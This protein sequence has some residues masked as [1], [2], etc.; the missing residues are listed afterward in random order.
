MLNELA[1]S[2]D[3]VILRL[4]GSADTTDVPL[5]GYWALVGQLRDRASD[6]AADSTSLSNTPWMLEQS[7]HESSL[8]TSAAFASIEAAFSAVFPGSAPIWLLVDDAHLVDE[9]SRRV[10]GFVATR[11][12]HV[13]ITIVCTAPA[14]ESAPELLQFQRILLDQLD[15]NDIASLVHQSRGVHAPLAVCAEIARASDGVPGVAEELIAALSDGQLCGLTPSRAYDLASGTAERIA[16]AQISKLNSATRAA[17]DTIAAIGEHHE[18]VAV[19]MLAS[20][21]VTLDELISNDLVSADS[22]RVRIRSSIL[23]RALHRQLKQSTI[24]DAHRALLERSAGLMSPID[25]L[26]HDAHRAEHTP[27]LADRLLAEAHQL[28][29]QG[30][31]RRARDFIALASRHSLFEHHAALA[32]LRAEI[33]FNAGYFTEVFAIAE[34]E[35]F[36]LPPSAERLALARIQH[37]ARFLYGERLSVGEALDE[38]ENHATLHPLEVLSFAIECAQISLELGAPVDA[39]RFLAVSDDTVAHAPT[40]VRLEYDY[41]A[42]RSDPGCA[43]EEVL[44]RLERWYREARTE[45]IDLTSIMVVHLIR[46]GLAEGIELQLRSAMRGDR[47]PLHRSTLLLYSALNELRRGRFDAAVEHLDALDALT[48]VDGF[49]VS[50]RRACRYSAAAGRGIPVVAWQLG[51]RPRS[52]GDSVIAARE[53]L[54]E[55]RWALSTGRTVDGIERLLA[56]IRVLESKDVRR[57]VAGDP[58]IEF[59]L[60]VLLMDAFVEIDRGA[61]AVAARSVLFSA[62]LDTPSRY[63]LAARAVCEALTDDGA[64]ASMEAALGWAETDRLPRNVRAKVASMCVRILQRN[65]QYARA[66]HVMQRRLW[67][68]PMSAVTTGAI[69][70]VEPPPPAVPSFQVLTAREREIALL[71][72]DGKRNREISALLFLSLRTVEAAM[73][74]VFRKLEVRS[75][76]ELV[77]HLLHAKSIN[78]FSPS[79]REILSGANPESATG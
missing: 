9:L 16:H 10:L 41:V 72:A 60:P 2:L 40:L 39:A 73:T 58:E 33:A 43:E 63:A 19:M 79:D 44:L 62:V 55:A 47:P 46:A 78:G 26:R 24:I 42:A 61:S 50:Y 20:G 71:A 38:C 32:V 3:G 15:E 76:T 18:D 49:A 51:T 59:D 69:N 22:G 11:A 25:I 13:P 8:S 34:R 35:L 57:A 23:E 5:S 6:V 29:A 56:A 45:P 30:D 74:R 65:G 7:G 36:Q 75:R 67:A 64:N 66:E 48:S 17:V 27:E 54:A 4:Q 37:L 77:N 14:L 52:P 1:T 70:T 31:L 21:S 12:T 68:L 28:S 53:N